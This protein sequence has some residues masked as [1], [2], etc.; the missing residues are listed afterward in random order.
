MSRGDPTG[1]SDHFSAVAWDYAIYRPRYPAALFDFIAALP[2]RRSLAW[3]AG[4]GSG[5]AAV[6]LAGR[7]AQVIAT[8]ASL[9][10]L[11][12][13]EPHPRVQY[14]MAPAERSGLEDESVDL[15]TVAQALH[16]FPLG[17]FYAEARRVLAPGGAIAVWTYDR[18]RLDEPA[19]D[20]LLTHFHDDVVGPYWPPARA[21]VDSGYRTLPF[22]FTRIPGPALELT[23]DWALGDVLG[24]VRSWSATARYRAALG[25][26]PV[27]PFATEAAALWGDRMAP[28]RI[29]WSLHLLA[30]RP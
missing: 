4:T 21:L 30:G 26:D 7:F 18:P 14:R 20:R 13:A 10:Q 27:E 9:A 11:A 17:L 12:A 3:D 28:R 22:P 24:Y 6:A 1:F 25:V 2:A 5:Q 23:A 8:D 16:W 29:R 19:L 15:V